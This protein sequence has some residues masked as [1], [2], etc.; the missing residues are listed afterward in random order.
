MSIQRKIYEQLAGLN[1]SEVEDKKDLRQRTPDFKRKAELDR[2]RREAEQR[3]MQTNGY[4]PEGEE[5]EEIASKVY[6]AV[7]K[8]GSA[9]GKAM[10]KLD[11]KLNSPN[12]AKTRLGRYILKKM[13]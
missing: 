7:K 10:D 6:G 4:E 9:Y 12:D 1:E 11:K 3:R 2:R 8:A 5:I 13:Q